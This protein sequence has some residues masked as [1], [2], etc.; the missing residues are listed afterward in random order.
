ME[1]EMKIIF[2]IETSSEIII[3]EL[4]KYQEFQ[5]KDNV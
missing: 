4:E 5:K 2:D 3:Y 1:R